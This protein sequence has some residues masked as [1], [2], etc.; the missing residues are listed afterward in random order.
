MVGSGAWACAAVRI[1][2]QNTRDADPSDEFVDDVSMWVYEEDC[3]VSARLAP[4]GSRRPTGHAAATKARTGGAA[5][6][7][8]QLPFM[9]MDGAQGRGRHP[10]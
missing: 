2:A 6:T 4:A 5:G 8:P 1:I 10:P 7:P 3:Q 9:D